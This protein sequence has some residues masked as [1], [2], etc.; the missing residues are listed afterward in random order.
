MKV[1][2]RSL[3]WP[4]ELVSPSATYSNRYMHVIHRRGGARRDPATGALVVASDLAVREALSDPNLSRSVPSSAAAEHLDDDMALV[5]RNLLPSLDPPLH[6]QV[7]RC[8]SPEMALRRFD[9][10]AFL[11]EAFSPLL[12][13]T[14]GDLVAS[15]A[16]PL[17]SQMSAHISGLSADTPHPAL[18]EVVSLIFEAGPRYVDTPANLTPL[19]D[20]TRD[21]IETGAGPGAVGAAHRA[22]DSGALDAPAAQMMALFGAIAGHETIISV[23]ATT[24]AAMLTRRELL[25]AAKEEPLDFAHEVLRLTSTVQ[26]FFFEA[27]R[28]TSISG[29]RVAAGTPVVVSYAGACRDSAVFRDPD[30]LRLGRG[31]GHLAFG[32]GTRRCLGAE[33]AVAVA[34]ETVRTVL[35]LPTGQEEM[36]IRCEWTENSFIHSPLSVLLARPSE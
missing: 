31:R 7:R 1:R 14:G 20:A 4:V 15:F 22:I 32:A 16:G 13:E 34:L 30:S 9:I 36:T 3:S 6:H 11:D 33:L 26:M 18:S 25:L 17:A 12:A 27:T 8:L 24:A 10:G 28:E 21:A 19:I 29:I 35:A 23:A 5:L 2:D